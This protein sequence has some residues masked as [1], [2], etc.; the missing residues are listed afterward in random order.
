MFSLRK[1][2][3]GNRQWDL[4]FIT[5]FISDLQEAGFDNVI[6]KLPI[7][8]DFYEKETASI[9]SLEKKLNHLEIPYKEFINQER[10]Y[11]AT[12][13]VATNKKLKDE[14]KILFVN[15]SKTTKFIDNIFPSGH[16]VPSQIYVQSPDPSRLYGLINYFH[17]YLT[18]KHTSNFQNTIK[19]LIAFF[20]LGLETINLFSNLS[21][22]FQERF[23]ISP[24]L[25]IVLVILSIYWLYIFL[26]TPKGLSV[27]QRETA[28]IQ[29][30]VS[31]AL[32][33]DLRDNPIAI[34]LITILTEVIVAIILKIIWP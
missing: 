22:F 30:F 25:D 33:G 14:I 28:T 34:I 1:N 24:W 17:A 12:I 13:L 16:S 9:D 3:G 6:F 15:T 4:A 26:S 20:I 18:P 32:K 27:N 8:K 7:D 19:G 31:R 29:S 5:K 11:A 23:Q 21:G 2:I 10:N